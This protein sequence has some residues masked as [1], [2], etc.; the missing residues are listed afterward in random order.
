MGHR[1]QAREALALDRL[2]ARDPDL[3]AALYVRDLPLAAYEQATAYI[4]NR[5]LL[6]VSLAA[7]DADVVYLGALAGESS[8]DKD[9]RF[10]RDATHLLSHVLSRPVRVLAPFRHLTKQELV[11]VYLEMFPEERGPDATVRLTRSCYA[12]EL[13]AVRLPGVVGCG[14][15]M[16][17]FRR[18]V[19]M[20]GNQIR[21]RYLHDPWDWEPVQ[22]T[23]ARARQWL[24]GLLRVPVAE[25]PAVARSNVQAGRAIERGRREGW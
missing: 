22:V 13:D 24:A 19:A 5:N 23:P 25:W 3:A 20:R 1:Y 8:R 4:P 15:C 18:W 12:P 7:Q 2:R 14:A 11:A 17:C 9:G 16:A 21:E 6:L 10:F